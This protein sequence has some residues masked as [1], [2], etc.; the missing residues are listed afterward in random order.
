MNHPDFLSDR[1]SDLKKSKKFWGRAAWL[2][3]SAVFV[4]PMITISV[5]VNSASDTFSKSEQREAFGPVFGILIAS[6]R[7]TIIGGG[8]TLIAL[9]VFVVSLTFVIKRGKSLQS[10]AEKIIL[11]EKKRAGIHP[12]S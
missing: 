8:F 7:T 4:F 5:I 9:I 11:D 6:L 10:L 1:L 3:A 2:S 12:R